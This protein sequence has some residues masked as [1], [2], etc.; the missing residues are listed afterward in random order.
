MMPH[1][2]ASEPPVSAA[3]GASEIVQI[4]L[5]ESQLVLGHAVQPG[6]QRLEPL[7]NKVRKVITDFA[8]I[9]EMRACETPT[10]CEISARLRPS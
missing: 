10:T 7:F 9:C 2:R 3:S 4:L 6:Y 8:F 1:A 5:D